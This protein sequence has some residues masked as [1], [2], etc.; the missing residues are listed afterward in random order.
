MNDE[1]ET[2]RANLMIVIKIPI[3]IQLVFVMI[4][5]IVKIVYKVRVICHSD[6]KIH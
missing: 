6:L 5:P 1:P 2:V 3:R 4:T